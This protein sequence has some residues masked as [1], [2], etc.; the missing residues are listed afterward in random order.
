MK[1]ILITTAFV[2]GVFLFSS[3]KKDKNNDPPV[4]AISKIFENGKLITEFTYAGKKVIRENNY[5]EITGLLDYAIAF[6]YDANGNMITEKQYNEP[7][8]LSGIVNY[9]RRPAVNL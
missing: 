7:N 6:D 2:T 9:N 4:T 8:K 3:C 1:T 5:D